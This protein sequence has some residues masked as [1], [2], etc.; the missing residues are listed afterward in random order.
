VLLMYQMT[1]QPVG[2]G[3]QFLPVAHTCFNLLDLPKYST[4]DILRAK[5]LQ[6]IQQSE[7]FALI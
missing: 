5:L 4:A 3:E 1:I 6:A 2:G 7:G